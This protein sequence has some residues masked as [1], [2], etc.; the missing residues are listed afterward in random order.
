M[1]QAVQTQWRVG[2][3]GATGLDYVAVLQLLRDAYPK[4]K[5]RLEIFN[6]IRVCERTQLECWAEQRDKK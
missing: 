3:A 2:M 4:R 1:W 6:D 5:K